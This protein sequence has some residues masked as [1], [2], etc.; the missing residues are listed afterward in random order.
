MHRAPLPGELLTSWYAR[1]RRYPDGQGLPE[2]KSVRD[3]AGR[4][5]HPDIF[6]AKAWLRF[7]SRHCDVPE[8]QLAGQAIAG[9]YPALTLDLAA[10]SW[11]PFVIGNRQWMPKPKLKICW[12]SRCLADDFAAGRPAHIRQDWV[13]ATTGFCHHHRWPLE[14]R[15]NVCGSPNW[16]FRAPARGALRMVCADCWRPLERSFQPSLE[17]NEAIQYCWQTVIAFEHEVLTALRGNTP[18]QFRLNFTSAGQ[19]LQEVRD[20]CTLLLADDRSD[21]ASLNSISCPAMLPGHLLPEF[22]STAAPYPL[23]TARIPLRRALIAAS[24]AI[25]MDA[26]GYTG[27]SGSD[28][29]PAL[30]TFLTRVDGSAI[31]HCMAV[32]DRW[33]STLIRRVTETRRAT[34]RSRSIARLKGCISALDRAFT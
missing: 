33:S 31:D 1:R 19:L 17:A 26:K 10:W 6:P 15:C 14:D 25:I 13:I 8:A 9:R 3:R 20:I 23:A 34:R 22:H 7:V 32:P 21:W 18:D 16:H 12:C 2:P 28:P 29:A 5:R 11:S 24:C 27:L 4:W 30:E